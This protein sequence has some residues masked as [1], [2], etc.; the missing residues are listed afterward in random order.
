MVGPAWSAA[1]VGPDPSE[2]PQSIDRIVGR[3]GRGRGRP[4]GRGM[5]A[6]PPASSWLVVTRPRPD[7][8]TRPTKGT[9]MTRM[10]QT[11]SGD[12]VHPYDFVRRRRW[13]AVTPPRITRH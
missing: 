12:D 8:M 3:E 4:T 2:T 10:T 5:P 9:A 6:A 13:S 1:A 7:R 11:A